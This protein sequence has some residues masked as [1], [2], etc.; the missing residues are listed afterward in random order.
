MKMLKVLEHPS[1]PWSSY[2]DRS[3]CLHRPFGSHPVL[4]RSVK[5][6]ELPSSV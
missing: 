2:S 6:R 1:R 4:A 5:F 3:K